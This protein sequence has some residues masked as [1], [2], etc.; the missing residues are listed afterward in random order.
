MD[1]A[2]RIRNS[3]TARSKNIAPVTTDIAAK[4]TISDNELEQSVVRNVDRCIQNTVDVY[5]NSNIT[6]GTNE[7]PISANQTHSMFATFMA[8]M[9]ADKAKLASTLEEK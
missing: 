3:S 5:G 6:S 2:L 7:S 8:A 1:R 9:Q 4:D